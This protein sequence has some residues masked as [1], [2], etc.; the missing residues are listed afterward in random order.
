MTEL[1]LSLIIYLILTGLFFL[2]WFKPGI[3]IW[4]LLL[5]KPDDVRQDNSIWEIIESKYFIW[6]PRILLTTG[7]VFITHV[8]LISSYLHSLFR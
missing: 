1:F 8:I 3:Y 5:Q 2:V 7:W 4:L 6:F